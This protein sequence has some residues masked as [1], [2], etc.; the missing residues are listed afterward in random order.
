MSRYRT[1]P[2]IAADFNVTPRRLKQAIR[3]HRIPVLK[4]GRTI[5]FDPEA[6]A[7]LEDAIRTYPEPP[8]P[9]VYG[10]RPPKP[11]A[12]RLPA[13]SAYERALKL[14]AT[15]SARPKRTSPEPILAK[16]VPFA[17]NGKTA[18]RKGVINQ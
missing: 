18:S 16:P 6:V 1:L 9:R 7:L 10:K 15:K 12:T 11:R 5:N 17:K 8:A 14:L 4:I 13:V 2:E 3:D